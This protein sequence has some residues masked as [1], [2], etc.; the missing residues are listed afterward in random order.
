MHLSIVLLMIIGLTTAAPAKFY[1]A[2]G[3]FKTEILSPILEEMCLDMSKTLCTSEDG[4]KVQYAVYDPDGRDGPCKCSDLPAPYIASLSRPYTF[5]AL[6]SGQ[7][8]KHCADV[9][10]PASKPDMHFDISEGEC[11]CAG[12]DRCID[13]SSFGVISH[14][15]G[16]DLAKL[17]NAMA[18]N[19]L[20]IQDRVDDLKTALRAWNTVHL[21]ASELFYLSKTVNTTISEIRV[22]THKSQA[23]STVIAR[24]LHSVQAR[25]A[26]NKRQEPT[27][28][29]SSLLTVDTAVPTFVPP[30][31]VD[32][33]P[34]L[35]QQSLSSQMQNE[36]TVVSVIPDFN[37]GN[38]TYLLQMEGLVATLIP[39]NATVY[40]ACGSIGSVE[41]V[42]I[43]VV[44]KYIK[45]G[46]P[47]TAVADCMV[48]AVNMY[49]PD[50]ITYW[51]QDS[52]GATFS[53]LGSSKV[54]DIDKIYTGGPLA[55]RLQAS[56]GQA[57]R[58]LPAHDA[59]LVDYHGSGLS[60]LTPT[61]CRD[62]CSE[63][64]KTFI[65][66]LEDFCACLERDR[67][68]MKDV[69]GLSKPDVG[70]ATMT[71]QACA[72]MECVNNNNQPAVYNP[73]TR[74]CW[75]KDPVYVEEVSNGWPSRIRSL[76]KKIGFRFL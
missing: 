52:A 71:A 31:K 40:L 33:T 63:E 50:I 5:I 30:P 49:T 59:T 67:E 17:K 20:R 6:T 47:Q 72:A 45:D 57:K 56:I 24:E 69:R 2:I 23:A 74:T 3:S 64:S 4:H 12:K 58:S 34:E 14:I 10:C 27:S 51:I 15:H 41:D 42:N 1:A 76:L 66:G 26:G 55:L 60:Q 65:Q 25:I 53:V 39:I 19:S 37:N 38:L 36:A 75:C 22:L 16:N 73:F 43:M 13:A 62:G 44:P 46:T 70:E 18:R 11:F 54:H 35:L 7:V 8:K 32:I 29:V 9:S 68:L 28:T 61:D 48:I 21:D